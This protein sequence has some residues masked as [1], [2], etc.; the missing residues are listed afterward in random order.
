VVVGLDLGMALREVA[1][2]DQRLR[3]G[4]DVELVEEALAPPRSFVT[5]TDRASDRCAYPTASA[6][7]SAIPRGA[8]EP[9]ASDRRRVR[10]EAESRYAAHDRYSTP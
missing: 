4:R 2:V 1:D 5:R 6:P 9:P 3:V 7:R 10:T 8:P